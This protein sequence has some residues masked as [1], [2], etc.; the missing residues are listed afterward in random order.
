MALLAAADLFDVLLVVVVDVVVVDVAR[1]P[2]LLS[3]GGPKADASAN[4]KNS[5]EVGAGHRRMQ[6]DAVRRSRGRHTRKNF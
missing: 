5:A 4:E 2:R 6:A 1:L 3:R